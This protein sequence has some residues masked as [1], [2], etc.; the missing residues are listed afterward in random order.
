MHLSFT[1]VCNNGYKGVI[2]DMTSSNFSQSAH[3]GKNYYC[4]PDLALNYE[5][6][7]GSFVPCNLNHFLLEKYIVK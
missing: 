7:S 1:S 2:F 4:F 5:Q 3:P 6:T